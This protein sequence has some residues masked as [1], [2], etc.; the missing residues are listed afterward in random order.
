M[1]SEISII[2]QPCPLLLIPFRRHKL[3]Y[4]HIIASFDMHG[5]NMNHFLG[6]PVRTLTMNNLLRKYFFLNFG[7]FSS[8]YIFQY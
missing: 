2:C 6:Q 7:I 3:Y 8:F 5:R 4:R 1:S